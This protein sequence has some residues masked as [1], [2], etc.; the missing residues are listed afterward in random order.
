MLSELCGPDA[1]SNL[2]ILTTFWDL[3]DVTVGAAREAE[4]IE[5]FWR[6]K[7]LT[8]GASVRR[9]RPLTPDCAWD[10]VD[11]FKTLTPKPLR[12][13]VEM[14]DDRKQFHET[15]AFKCLLGSWASMVGR[16]WGAEQDF[17]EQ[18]FSEQDSSEEDFSPSSFEDSAEKQGSPPLIL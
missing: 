18:D 1:K 6:P 7:F 4:L 11:L 13:Q 5:K 9:L 10:V 17:S 2:I 3:M 14:A 16:L 8:D 12:V 15:S